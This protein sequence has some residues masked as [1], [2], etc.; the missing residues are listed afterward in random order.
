VK[1]QHQSQGVKLQHQSQGVKW[2]HQPQGA[3]VYL[4]SQGVK[5]Q[6]QSQGVKWYHILAQGVKRYN[7]SRMLNNTISPVCEIVPYPQC[8]K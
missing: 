6:H 2:Q 8:V 4:K 7:Q 5:W 1:W 3:K